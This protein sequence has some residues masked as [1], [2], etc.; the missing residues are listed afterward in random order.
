MQSSYFMSECVE[1]REELEKVAEEIRACT[2]CPL[3]ASRTNAV[4]GEGNPCNRVIFIGEAPGSNEDL[5]GRPF[6]GAAGQLLTSLLTSNGIPR[7]SVFITNVVKC[8][9][10]GNRDPRDEEIQACMPFLLRQLKLI[11]PRLIVTLGRHS[12]RTVLG[13]YGYNADSVMAVRGRVYRIEAE[14]GELVVFPTLHPAAALY[15]PRLRTVLE[16]DFKHIATILQGKDSEGQ[17]TLDKF[18]TWKKR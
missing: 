15:N 3:Y 16:D 8:R 2:R 13:Y 4:P 10:P 7:E 12:T 18:F 9:P 6:V 14:W 11:K 1:L 17:S 5:Q